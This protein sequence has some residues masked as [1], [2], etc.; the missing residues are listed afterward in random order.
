MRASILVPFDSLSNL[1]ATLCQ[2]LALAESLAAK[3]ILLRV[4]LSEPGASRSRQEEC[5]Y[6]ELKALQARCTAC[7]AVTQIAVMQ[8]PVE[9]AIV[10]FAAEE[11][12]DLIFSSQIGRLLNREEQ[13]TPAYEA[14]LRRDSWHPAGPL[15]DA[16][17]SEALDPIGGLARAQRAA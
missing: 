16:L 1:Q 10:Q 4:N 9:E 14:L 13:E 12:I 6:S 17:G 15:V 2:A 3:V 5:L 7:D 8:G 11:E